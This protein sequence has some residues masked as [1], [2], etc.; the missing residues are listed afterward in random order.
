VVPPEPLCCRT[1][2][3]Q[4]HLTGN[5]IPLLEE[6][7]AV[8]ATQAPDL[9]EALRRAQHDGVTQLTPDGKL[10]SADRLGEQIISVKVEQIDAWYSGNIVNKAATSKY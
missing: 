10:F 3:G 4:R 2:P 8:L 5:R 6:I 9:Q 1:G 7:I